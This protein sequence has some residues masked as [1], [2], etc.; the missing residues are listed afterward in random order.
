MGDNIYLFTFTKEKYNIKAN[1]VVSTSSW[2]HFKGTFNCFD[3]DLLINFKRHV[4]VKVGGSLFSHYNSYYEL[5]IL[6][7]V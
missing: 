5:E 4:V 2:D 6:N 1:S 7:W 3:V